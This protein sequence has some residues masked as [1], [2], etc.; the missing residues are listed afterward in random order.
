M[1]RSEAGVVLEGCTA[2]IVVL[3]ILWVTLR[4]L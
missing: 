3:A 1:S 4:M 2:L